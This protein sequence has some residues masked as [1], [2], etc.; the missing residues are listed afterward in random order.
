MEIVKKSEGE[1]ARMAN[2]LGEDLFRLNIHKNPHTNTHTKV[3]SPV[4]CARKAS[5]LA[6]KVPMV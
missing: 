2:I 1:A 4:N 3:E 6:K 5:V